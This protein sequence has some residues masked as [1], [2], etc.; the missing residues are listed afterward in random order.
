MVVCHLSLQ[1][2]WVPFCN[3]EIESR[4]QMNSVFVLNRVRVLL[5]SNFIPIHVM[6]SPLS[7]KEISLS[8]IGFMLVD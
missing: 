7:F 2:S 4:Q 5:F 3:N 6:S 8:F 1:L